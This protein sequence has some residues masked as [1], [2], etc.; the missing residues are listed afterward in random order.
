MAKIDK[1]KE[2]VVNYRMIWLLSITSLF[3]FKTKK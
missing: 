2:K 1:Q 3:N